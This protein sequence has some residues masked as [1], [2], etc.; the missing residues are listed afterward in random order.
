MERNNYFSTFRTIIRSVLS[1]MRTL[2]THRFLKKVKTEKRGKGVCVV[3][4]ETSGVLEDIAFENCMFIFVNF[5]AKNLFYLFLGKV[6]EYRFKDIELPFGYTA[7][8]VCYRSNCSSLIPTNEK[9]VLQVIEDY[10]PQPQPYQQQQQQQQSTN[11][12]PSMTR[13]SAN[14][15]IPSATNND[16]V[17][18][19]TQD[20][21]SEFTSSFTRVISRS[22]P[23]SNSLSRLQTTPP[24]VSDLFLGEHLIQSHFD[25]DFSTIQSSLSSSKISSNVNS[26]SKVDSGCSQTSSKTLSLSVSPFKDSPLSNRIKNSTPSHIG[27]EHTEL[28]VEKS[29]LYQEDSRSAS[30]GS[31]VFTH[32]SEIFGNLSIETS[33]DDIDD[34]ISSCNFAATQSQEDST[35][36]SN[37]NLADFFGSNCSLPEIIMELENFANNEL[38]QLQEV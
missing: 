10:N 29:F 3:D 4:Y 16:D 7:I 19:S 23:S 2:P 15:Q 8:E 1:Y 9:R 28:P 33:E 6:E 20:S 34:L 26:I 21:D 14:I 31:D 35:K 27:I 36:L 38:R 37:S 24:D 25:V 13:K 5:K 22:G 30:F 12:T 32:S 11:N 18:D 17:F